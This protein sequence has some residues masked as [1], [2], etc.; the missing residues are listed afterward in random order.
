MNKDYLKN[1][2]DK[3]V[4]E[5]EF[6]LNLYKRGYSIDFITDYYYKKNKKKISKDII[7]CS[8]LDILLSDITFTNLK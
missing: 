7:R 4:S 2:N 6:I 1:N 3:I 5:D 8:V